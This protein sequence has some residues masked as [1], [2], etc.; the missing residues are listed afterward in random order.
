VQLLPEEDKEVM[1]QMAQEQVEQMKLFHK[2]VMEIINKTAQVTMRTIKPVFQEG[3]LVWL[4]AKN[5]K[6]PYRT[7]K[8]LPR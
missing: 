1:N 8:L 4:E 6:L 3:E 7:P 5:L 2:L